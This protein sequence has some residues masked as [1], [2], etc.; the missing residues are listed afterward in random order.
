MLED[1]PEIE[2]L[3]GPLHTLQREDIADNL[4]CIKSAAPA[5]EPA[6]GEELGWLVCGEEGWQ[7]DEFIRCVSTQVTIHI[8]ESEACVRS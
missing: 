4:C 7:P 8:N 5:E 2:A 6:G 3:P 1:H